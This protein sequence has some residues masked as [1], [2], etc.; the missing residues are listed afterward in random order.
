MA[1]L[2]LMLPDATGS[3]RF[4]SALSDRHRVIH[5]KS[6]R[7]LHRLVMRHPV[8]LCVLDL[9]DPFR[10]VTFTQLQR[11]RRR[12]ESLAL[13]IHSDFRGRESALFDLGRIQVDG[14]LQASGREGP[15]EIREAVDW[16]LARSAAG[17]VVRSLKGRLPDFALDALSWA[18]EHAEQKPSVDRMTVAIGSTPRALGRDLK[19]QDLPTPHKL[20]VWGRLLQAA[21]L[22][23][24]C[25]CTVDT[26]AFRLGYSTGGALRRAMK[27]NTGLPPSILVQRGGLTAALD[28]FVA[29]VTGAGASWVRPTAV[30]K[31]SKRRW[32]RTES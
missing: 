23:E 5:A 11:F 31:P 18:V 9:Y 3:A 2:A 30:A 1:V 7:Q 12:H 13:L 21:R 8:D 22:L 25:E 4:A 24:S 27:R 14:V 10:P 20:L 6:W 28:A 26:V 17:R 19:S 32:A 29:S 15:R 16:A